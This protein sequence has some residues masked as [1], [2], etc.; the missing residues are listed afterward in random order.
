MVEVAAGQLGQGSG[1]PL[2]PAA[3]ITGVGGRAKGGQ[4][5][6]TSWPA[7]AST[8]PSMV[9]RLSRVGV[10]HRPA[11]G[12][13]SRAAAAAS[14]RP[15]GRGDRRPGGAGVG[16]APGRVPSTGSASAVT[17]GGRWWVPWARTWAWAADSAPAP[18]AW[19]VPVR[20]PQH[21]ARAVRTALL[22]AGAPSA[23]G[24]AARPR[25]SRPPRRLGPRPPAAVDDRDPAQPLA[26]QAVQEP[27]PHPRAARTGGGEPVQVAG[28][29]PA[30]GGLQGVQVVVQGPRGGWAEWVFGFMAGSYQPHRPRQAPTRKLWTPSS[31]RFRPPTQPGRAA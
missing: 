19:P 3:G 21:R 30:G 12:W 29:Q 10:S 24:C 15:A 7:S 31:G 4:A 9:T 5:A 20:G 18:T 14:G 28:G 22:A 6:R 27:P 26:V 23:G 16:P 2:A 13:R 17:C 25:S 8:T 11:A 1:G